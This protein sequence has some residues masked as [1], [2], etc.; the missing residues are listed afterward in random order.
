MCGATSSTSS[1]SFYYFSLGRQRNGE[2][3]TEEEDESENGVLLS[4][5]LLVSPLA[6]LLVGNAKRAKD[7]E[8]IN[9][10]ILSVFI[11]L[12]GIDPWFIVIFIVTCTQRV[13]PHQQRA[14]IEE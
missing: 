13:Q 2:I 12:L 3:A 14:S 4:L 6:A 11:N 8:S 1:S 9:I 7:A 10:L 5:S